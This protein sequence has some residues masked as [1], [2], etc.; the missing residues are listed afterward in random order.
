MTNLGRTTLIELWNLNNKRFKSPSEQSLW[1]GIFWKMPEFRILKVRSTIFCVYFS[2][3]LWYKGYD[4]KRKYSNL[5]SL[6]IIKNINVCVV[7]KACKYLLEKL[8]SKVELSFRAT[9]AL[10]RLLLHRFI[11]LNRFKSR[12]AEIIFKTVPG[13]IC[14]SIVYNFC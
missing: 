13:S 11:A 10:K 2:F 6:F 9:H 3:N 8:E 7:N 12:F 14:C 5:K 4:L 1:K